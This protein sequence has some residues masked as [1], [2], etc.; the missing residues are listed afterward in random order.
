[1]CVL[2]GTETTIGGTRETVEFKD[3]VKPPVDDL[4]NIVRIVSNETVFPRCSCWVW[5]WRSGSGWGRS[6]C[7][8]ASRQASITKHLTPMSSQSARPPPISTATQHK[9]IEQT[10]TPDAEV[11]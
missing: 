8:D 1:M 4:S 10:K 3:L 5:R 7:P 9:R 6:A 2:S 11:R